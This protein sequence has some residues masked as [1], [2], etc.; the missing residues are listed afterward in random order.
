M[1]D[2]LLVR[3][4]VQT[5]CKDYQQSTKVAASLREKRLNNKN[6]ELKDDK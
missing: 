6:L 2:V 4:W 3:I 1:T 5:I